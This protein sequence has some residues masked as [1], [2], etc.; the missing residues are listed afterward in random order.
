MHVL[1]KIDVFD[2]VL[3]INSFYITLRVRKEVELKLLTHGYK[4]LSTLNRYLN[5]MT[6]IIINFILL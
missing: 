5:I 3:N 2:K 1:N 6:I 4:S